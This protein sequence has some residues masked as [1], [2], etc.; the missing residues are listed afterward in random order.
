MIHN[1]KKKGFTFIEIMIVVVIIIIMTSVVL[2]TV[3][4]NKSPRAVEVAARQVAAAIRE[5]QNNALAGKQA[6]SDTSCGWGMAAIGDYDY[7]VFYNRFA[8]DP[9][10]PSC[11]SCG[12]ITNC[13]ELT[14]CGCDLNASRKYISPLAGSGFS[15][16]YADYTLGNK[17]KFSSGNNLYFTLPHAI[18]YDFSGNS[19]NSISFKLES[20]DDPSEK[21]TICVYASGRVEEEKGDVSC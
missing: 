20:E 10:S 4:N 21:Y 12:D 6:G 13:S 1:S 14:S 17:V 5:A 7:K 15:E 18:S 3:G 2:I 19:F 8:A 16:H 11:A 9:F